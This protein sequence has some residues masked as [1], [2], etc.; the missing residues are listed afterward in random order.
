MADLIAKLN[1]WQIRLTA[2]CVA[3]GIGLIGLFWK[4]LPP[5]IPLLYSQSWGSEQLVKPMWLWLI[6][7][8]N[9]VLGWVT[10]FV[11]PRL[12]LDQLLTVC[13]LLSIM[14]VQGIIILGL[15]RIVVLVI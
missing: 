9:L 3:I 10:A 15:I 6:P 8:L 7:G 11:L 4:Q 12:K 13:W 5:E 14:A 2:G 1:L